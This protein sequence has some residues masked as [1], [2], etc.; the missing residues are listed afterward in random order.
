MSRRSAS[1]LTC[2]FCGDSYYVKP[3]KRDQTRFCSRECMMEHQK[4]RVSK[5]CE[6][7]GDEYEVKASRSEQTRFCSRSCKDTWKRKE[8]S[9]HE[10]VECAVCGCELKRKPWEVAN[11]DRYYCS[12]KC[13]GRWMSA[14]QN[15]AD[16]PNWRGGFEHEFGANWFEMRDAVIDRDQICQ[17]CGEDGSSTFLDVHHTFLGVNLRCRNTPIP[18]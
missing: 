7:C 12:F 1:D 10:I 9:N 2:E 13:Q 6:Y 17:A 18:W 4:N 11:T 14:N 5:T 15:G 16:N 8:Y 3:C